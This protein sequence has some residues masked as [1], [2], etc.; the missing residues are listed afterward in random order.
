MESELALCSITLFAV[1]MK[2]YKDEKRYMDKHR[3]NSRARNRNLKVLIVL[4]RYFLAMETISSSFES[5]YTTNLQ[6][7]FPV[8]GI[9]E[10]PS[11]AVCATSQTIAKKGYKK[12]LIKINNVGFH[13][14]FNKIIFLYIF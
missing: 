2:N 5:E 11:G 9:F 6:L 10:S 1:G 14:L 7:K 12:L 4:T 3:T 8:T 13:F